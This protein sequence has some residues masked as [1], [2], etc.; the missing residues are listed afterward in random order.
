MAEEGKFKEVTYMWPKPGG[1]KPVKKV[2]YVTKIGDF[3]GIRA[4]S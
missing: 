2:S 4:H 3:L 1:T